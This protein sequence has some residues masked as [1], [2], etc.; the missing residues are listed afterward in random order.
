M[1]ICLF[2]FIVNYNYDGEPYLIQ[3]NG[4]KGSV[5]VHMVWV[6]SLKYLDVEADFAT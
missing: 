6:S 4:E 1:L 3:H 2:L 5:Q